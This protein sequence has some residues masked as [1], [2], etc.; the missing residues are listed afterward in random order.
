MPIIYG[1]L[2]AMM[3]DFNQQSSLLF[4]NI[5]EL[6]LVSNENKNSTVKIPAACAEFSIKHLD[7]FEFFG[8]NG[9]EFSVVR[10]G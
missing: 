2:V 6:V 5:S 4:P 3:V 7:M 9:I 8:E 10:Q 1:S